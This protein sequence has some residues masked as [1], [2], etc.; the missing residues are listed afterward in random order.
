MVKQHDHRYAK[1]RP[2]S[3]KIGD[4]GYFNVAACARTRRSQKTQPIP[5]VGWPTIRVVSS[6]VGLIGSVT[7]PADPLLPDSF[8]VCPLP[9]GVGFWPDSPGLWEA[10]GKMGF[11][12]SASRFAATT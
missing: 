6:A 3:R 10:Y 11:E 7:P 4:I 5:P 2:E 1:H 8:G 9:I 12:V